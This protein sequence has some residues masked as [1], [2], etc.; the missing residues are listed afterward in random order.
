MQESRN[1]QV[2]DLWHDSKDNEIVLLIDQ[3]GVK[4][5]CE[6]DYDYFR[7]IVVQPASLPF[8][9]SSFLVLC[10]RSINDTSWELFARL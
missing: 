7:C 8:S 9:D 6:T 1:A 5:G 3:A 10:N 4:P 2:G